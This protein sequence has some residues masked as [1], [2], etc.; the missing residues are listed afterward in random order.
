[1]TLWRRARNEVAGA[2]R[3]VRY[4]LGRPDPDAEK[5]GPA[6]AGEVRY[7]DVTST[8][9]STFGGF[10]ATGGLRTTYGDELVPRP[11]RLA[12][13]AAFGALAVA[14]AAGGYFAVVTGIDALVGDKPAGAEP[15]PLAAQAPGGSGGDQ[16]NSGLGRGTVFVPDMPAPAPAATAHTIRTLPATAGAPARQHATAP[17]RRGT[18]DGGV[19]APRP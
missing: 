13:V 8:G 2:W 11:R 5:A 3:S 17:R 14:G 12:A 18:V 9:M 16:S 1:M 7:E 15:Y 6:P 4:D 19:P 10:G